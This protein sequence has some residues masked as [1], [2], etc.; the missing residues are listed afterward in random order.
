[1]PTRKV[2]PNEFG[3]FGSYSKKLGLAKKIADRQMAKLTT[4]PVELRKKTLYNLFQGPV[5]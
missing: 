2:V 3:L 4:Q 5:L 1:M